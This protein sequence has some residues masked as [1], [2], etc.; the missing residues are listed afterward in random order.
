MVIFRRNHYNNRLYLSSNNF[1]A[2]LAFTQPHT[3]T[4]TVSDRFRSFI[5]TKVYLL[6]SIV[7]MIQCFVG[8]KVYLE[9]KTNKK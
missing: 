1:E 8:A 9:N 2:N 4:L 5:A 7:L 3:Y 6:K